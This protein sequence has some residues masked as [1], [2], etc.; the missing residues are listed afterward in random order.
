[1]LGVIAGIPCSYGLFGVF[2]PE[3]FVLYQLLGSLLSAVVIGPVLG[4]VLH[5]GLAAI[6]ERKKPDTD[7][8]EWS[9]EPEHASSNRSQ[10]D[11][12][13]DSD[14]PVDVD[15]VDSTSRPAEQQ[16]EIP[17]TEQNDTNTPN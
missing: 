12:T 2:A 5:H 4:I 8:E 3:L 11:E 15:V 17:T 6:V 7:I 9:I 1:M 13:D 14:R 10:L 16:T